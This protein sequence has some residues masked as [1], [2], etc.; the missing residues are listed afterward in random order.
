MVVKDEP[1]RQITKRLRAAGFIRI[2]TDGR[3]SKWRHPSGVWVPVP[4][5]HR[6]ISAGVV[7]KIDK[8]IEESEGK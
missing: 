8:A 1:A 2:S 6:M 4:E 7:R 5:S 3:H